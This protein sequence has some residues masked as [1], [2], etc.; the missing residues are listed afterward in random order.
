MSKEVT[1]KLE[2]IPGTASKYHNCVIKNYV[3][4]CYIIFHKYSLQFSNRGDLIDCWAHQVIVYGPESVELKSLLI[5]L[6]NTCHLIVSLVAN[7]M[8]DE[9]EP[10]RKLFISTLQTN[11]GKAMWV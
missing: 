9:V 3:Y 8:V 10:T 2:A 11:V 5:I 7:N 4:K 1:R 6:G